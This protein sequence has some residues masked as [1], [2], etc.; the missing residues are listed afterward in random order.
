M[1]G[2]LYV[3]DLLLLSYCYNMLN[4]FL[5]VSMISIGFCKMLKLSFTMCSCT[6]STSS[7]WYISLYVVSIYVD[8]LIVCPILC[9]IIA[10]T[11]VEDCVLLMSLWLWLWSKMFSYVF[12]MTIVGCTLSFEK[13]LKYGLFVYELDNTQWL[14]LCHDWDFLIFGCIHC[15]CVGLQPNCCL[16]C[17]YQ[18]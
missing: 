2:K 17:V 13:K 18:F 8:C 14:Y 7:H 4:A 12:C 16:C 15:H 3:P 9:M 11:K 10:W 6:H 1:C 5:C